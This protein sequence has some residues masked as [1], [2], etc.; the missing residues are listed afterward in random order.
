MIAVGCVV[1]NV[2]RQFPVF[3]WAA[4]AAPLAKE[5]DVEKEGSGKST[6][7]H[8]R[9]D[10]AGGRQEEGK[11]LGEE[12]QGDVKYMEDAED[13]VVSAGRGIVL[14]ARMYV[15][16]EELEML[17]ILAERMRELQETNEL[18]KVDTAGTYSSTSTLHDNGG[19][20]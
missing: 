16:E 19:G 3:W 4:S 1:N 9:E 13:V 12:G 5:A 8:S 10:G 2:Q 15:S 6:G 20:E 18:H 7:M 11:V 14:P 17:R